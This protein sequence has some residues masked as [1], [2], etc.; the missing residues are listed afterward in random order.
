MNLKKDGKVIARV[1]QLS[2]TG[3]LRIKMNGSKIA[4]IESGIPSL[5]LPSSSSPSAGSK[6]KDDPFFHLKDDNAAAEAARAKL[7][8][9]LESSLAEL[10]SYF[11]TEVLMGNSNSG[12][13][14]KVNNDNSQYD[15]NKGGG[16]NRIGSSS[17][18][19]SPPSPYST[20]RKDNNDRIPESVWNALADI[21][22][23]RNE[24][25]SSTASDALKLSD[26]VEVK[27]CL[28]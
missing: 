2:G 5:I 17:L 22:S 6:E 21:D 23:V 8:R 14:N 13:D 7:A 12:G 27:T 26:V 1:D 18:V 15:D 20:L 11:K 24:L 19:Q 25:S 4:N 28:G 3:S 16:S 10:V 9:R